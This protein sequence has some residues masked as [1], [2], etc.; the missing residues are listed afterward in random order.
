MNPYY[1]PPRY[2]SSAGEID[3]ATPAAMVEKE[4]PPRPKRTGRNWYLALGGFFLLLAGAC[5]V[6]SNSLNWHPVSLSPRVPPPAAAAG[7]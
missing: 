6:L 3:P 5:L 7:K 2:D 1:Q 4:P